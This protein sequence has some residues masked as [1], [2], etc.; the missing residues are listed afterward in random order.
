MGCSS[1]P[2]GRPA[3]KEKGNTRSAIKRFCYLYYDR[4]SVV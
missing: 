3:F 2:A 1:V 4:F